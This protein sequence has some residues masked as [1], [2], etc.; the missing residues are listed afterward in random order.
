MAY[1]LLHMEHIGNIGNVLYCVTFEQQEK[2]V[3][4]DDDDDDIMCLSL[5]CMTHELI[6]KQLRYQ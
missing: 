3:D 6:I 1:L 4:D 5:L 2:Y